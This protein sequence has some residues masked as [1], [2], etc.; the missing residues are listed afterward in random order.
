MPASR[1]TA[2]TGNGGGQWLR[3]YPSRFGL[4]A[5]GEHSRLYRLTSLESHLVCLMLCVLSFTPGEFD[6]YIV[7]LTGTLGTSGES[8]IARK[9][10][11]SYSFTSLA[12]TLNP[13][14]TSM[15]AYRGY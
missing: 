4:G 8:V 2:R 14:L 3:N 1:W 13:R 12:T 9:E 15:R 6:D 7:L 11:G 10:A 5:G